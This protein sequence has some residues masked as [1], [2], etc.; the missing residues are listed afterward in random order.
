MKKKLGKWSAV[1]IFLII[2]HAQTVIGQETNEDDER[3][4]LDSAGFLEGHTVFINTAFCNETK[5]KGTVI[6]S[7]NLPSGFFL[8]LR[9]NGDTILI[10]MDC[11]VAITILDSVSWI[12]EPFGCVSYETHICGIPRISGLSLGHIGNGGE[13]FYV[14][15]SHP[16][17]EKVVL[18]NQ[19]YVVERTN[20]GCCPDA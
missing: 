7:L 6:G 2:A 18:V 5:I 14:L 17:K 10:R 11:I 1:L 20:I 4:M 3:I 12:N 15:K 16:Q 9:D 13:A 8:A 19:R